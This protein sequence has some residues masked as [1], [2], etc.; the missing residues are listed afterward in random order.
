[1]N[2]CNDILT[3]NILGENDEFWD[4][5]QMLLFPLSALSPLLSSV[6]Q[7]KAKF[8]LV[9]PKPMNLLITQNPS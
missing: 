3:K 8:L 7:D 2:F 6:N 4:I 5:I 9:P 1:M